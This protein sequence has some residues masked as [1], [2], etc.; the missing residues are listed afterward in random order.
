MPCSE[1]GWPVSSP[2][3]TCAARHSQS[4]TGGVTDGIQR[5]TSSSQEKTIRTPPCCI[6]KHG[7]A[8]LGSRTTTKPPEADSRN[9]T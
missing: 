9:A 2:A 1:V 5:S 4:T 8:P 3:A 7:S 6:R